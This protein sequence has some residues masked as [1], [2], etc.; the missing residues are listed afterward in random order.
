MI[1]TPGVRRFAL[2][3]HVTSS[4]GWLGAACVFLAHAAIGLNSEDPQIVRGVYLVMEPAARF[5]LL[6]LATAALATGLVQSLGTTWGLFRHYWVVFKLLITMC[7][8]VIL[9]I[10]MNTFRQMAA[11]AAD[12]LVDLEMVRN[13]SPAL[14]AGLALAALITATALA[15]YKPAGLTPYGRRMQAESEK[16]TVAGNWMYAAA[17]VAIVLML[18]IL[19]FHLTGHRPRSH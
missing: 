9:L 1:M 10:Y 7:A 8:T 13:P 11:V 2:T 14:H 19:A 17:V 4:V 12:P 6:P 18:L 15:I 5:A 3:T 16:R